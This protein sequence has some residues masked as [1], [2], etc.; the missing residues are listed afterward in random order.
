VARVE[1]DHL[2]KTVLDRR[3]ETIDVLRDVTLAV[4]DGELLVLLGPSGAGKT[5]L[6]R[7][8]AGL[9]EATLGTISIDG[10]EVTKMPARDRDVAMVFQ[11]PALFP[12]LTAL[13]NLELG[14][15]WRRV[16]SAERESRVREVVELLGLAACLDRRPDA[17]S[18]GERQRVAMGRALVRQ[19]R[20]FLFD[21]PLSSLDPPLRAQLR[22]ELARLHSRLGTTT[23]HVTHDQVEAMALGERVAVMKA[24]VLQQTGRP[25]DLY[26]QPANVFVA[27]F[28]G[29]PPMSLMAG[30]IEEVQGRL[31]FAACDPGQSPPSDGLRIEIEPEG[32]GARARHLRRSIILGF[33]PE[34]VQ[35]LEPLSDRALSLEASVE[36]VDANGADVFLHLRSGGQSFVARASATGPWALNQRV[37]VRFDLRHARLFDSATGQAVEVA[38]A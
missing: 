30:R 17:L 8:I 35:I 37:A 19:P 20:V 38:A 25:L 22:G 6:L 13:E 12:H 32:R 10:R 28:L 3:G 18:G 7:L 21:E 36:R 23:I 27:G 33:H 4:E 1:I 11:H 14:L 2:T 29:S 34:H 26:R 5:T 31:W 16:P 9:E 15:K 24:G